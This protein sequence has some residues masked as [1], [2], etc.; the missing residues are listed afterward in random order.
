MKMTQ[1]LIRDRN[2]S[3]VYNTM[4]EIIDQ[5]YKYL[6][7]IVTKIHKLENYVDKYIITYWFYFIK[8]TM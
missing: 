3:D 8:W 7:Y 2:G 4:K 5:F 6:L 1:V